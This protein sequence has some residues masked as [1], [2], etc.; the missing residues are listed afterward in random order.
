MGVSVGVSYDPE[1]S[2]TAKYAHSF[3]GVEAVELSC[4]P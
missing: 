3:L 1:P 4:E 2:Y